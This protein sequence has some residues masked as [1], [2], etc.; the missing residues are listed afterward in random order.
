MAA[1][2]P[3]KFYCAPALVYLVLS[4]IAIISAITTASVFTIVLKIIFVLI[5]AWFLNYLCDSGYSAISWF[6]V[7]LPLIFFVLMI[8]ISFEVLYYAS[9]NN[10]PAVTSHPVTAQPTIRLF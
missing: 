5:W 10:T 7:F 2:L 1:L 9:K 4:A 8:F 6:L 3:S